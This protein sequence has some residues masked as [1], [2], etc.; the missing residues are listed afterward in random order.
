LKSRITKFIVTAVAATAFAVPAAV[1]S[2][3]YSVP[4]QTSQCGEAHG[5]F[6][7]LGEK[8]FRHDLGQGDNS[9]EGSLTLGADG[10]ATGAANSAACKA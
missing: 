7:A 5:A 3:G 9:P 8:G 10:P 4:A 2:P 6:G 1:A